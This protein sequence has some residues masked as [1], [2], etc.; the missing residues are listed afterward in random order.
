MQKTEA[1]HQAAIQYN[2]GLAEAAED[3]A[4]SLEHEEV[5]KWCIA[6]GKQHRFHAKRHKSALNK[7]QTKQD[8]DTSPVEVM[9]DGLDVP[10]PDEG[11]E[12]EEILEPKTVQAEAQLTHQG[13]PAPAPEADVISGS[14][15][16]DGCVGEHQPMEPSCEYY[17]N[18]SEE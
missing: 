9:T 17:P 11:E 7:L 3:L 14:A 4:P 10:E 12:V 6:V 2:E 5:K 16:S 18:K 15:F 1:Y 13:Q 8:Q